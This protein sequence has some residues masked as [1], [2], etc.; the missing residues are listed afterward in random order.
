MSDF[1]TRP[2]RSVLYVPAANPRAIAK[3]STLQCDVVV[4]DLEDAVAPDAKAE[5]RR[6]LVEAF[7]FSD[8]DRRESVIRVNAPGTTDFPLDM[9]AVAHCTPDAVLLPKVEH[10]NA[11]DQLDEACR[12]RQLGQA[13]Q[14]WAMVETPAAL[15]E[16]DR[17]VLAGLNGAHRLNCLVV[18]TNDLVKDTG[19]SADHNRVYLLSWLMQAVLVAR[20][21]GV[22]VLDGVWNDFADTAG[23]HA[24]A[25]QGREMGFDGKT[26]IH[27]AQIGPANLAFMARPEALAHARLVV[28]TFAQPEHAQ[29]GVINLQGKMVERLH[30]AQAMRL[31]AMDAAIR[32]RQ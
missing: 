13:V 30:L 16:L 17:L 28:D 20:R 24:E 19:V 15:I 18:G 7:R 1:S 14:A 2:R 32:E 22:T 29:S 23:F 21:R 31:L 3:A 9:D 26:L 11:F 10:A 4:F 25:V 5:A 27:P 8:W 6:H 12:Q